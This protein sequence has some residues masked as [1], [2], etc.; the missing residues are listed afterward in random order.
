MSIFSTFLELHFSGLKSIL[1][2]PEYQKLFVSEFFCSKKSYKKKVDFL[3]KTMDWPLCKKTTF[4]TLLELHFSKKVE[5]SMDDFVKK[6]TFFL[7]LFFEQKKPETNRL[8]YSGYK[9]MLYRPEK[10]SSHKVEK[11]DIL[12][13]G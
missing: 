13:T 8:L 10:W 3:T 7:Y 5:K 4:L 2:Y 1:F 12:Q 6:S 11:I 9:R